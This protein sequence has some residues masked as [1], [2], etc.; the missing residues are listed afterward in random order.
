MLDCVDIGFIVWE[1]GTFKLLVICGYWA[2]IAKVSFLISVRA[3]VVEL[4]L[5]AGAPL[6][7]LLTVPS[8]CLF[9]LKQRTNSL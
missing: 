1:L 6:Y 2:D 8:H 5:P 3:S 4:L 9:G 7:F